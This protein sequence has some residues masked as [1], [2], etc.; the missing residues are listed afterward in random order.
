MWQRKGLKR[1]IQ[2]VSNLEEFGVIEAPLVGFVFE[3]SPFHFPEFF[4]VKDPAFSLERL[5]KLDQGIFEVVPEP[6][7]DM[8]AVVLEGGFRPDFT[9]YLG[10]S[11][12]EVKDDTIGYDAPSIHPAFGE[13]SQ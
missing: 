2:I 5:S 4:S 11:G 6:L 3:Q 8:G 13:T 12:P 1:L 10:E 9:H 7:D